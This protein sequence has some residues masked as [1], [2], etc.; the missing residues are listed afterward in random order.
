MYTNYGNVHITTSLDDVPE[1]YLNK[2]NHFILLE[3]DDDFKS[4]DNFFP[5]NMDLNLDFN[6]V[7]YDFKIYIDEEIYDEDLIYNDAAAQYEKSKITELKDRREIALK[8][9]M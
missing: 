7:F 6:K 5:I 1:K 3:K 8:I 9:S 2:Y 4:D